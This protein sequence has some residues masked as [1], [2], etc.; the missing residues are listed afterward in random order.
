LNE[1]VW[2]NKYIR[3]ETKSKIYKATVLSI[4]IYAV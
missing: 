2:R 3:K 1:L 4:M